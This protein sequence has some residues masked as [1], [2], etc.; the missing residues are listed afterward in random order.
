MLVSNEVEKLK[1]KVKALMLDP[2]ARDYTR[3]ILLLGYG[4]RYGPLP[5]SV[6][7]T[8]NAVGLLVE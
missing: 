7:T 5:T 3:G 6:V 4:M 1:S 8:C 2:G